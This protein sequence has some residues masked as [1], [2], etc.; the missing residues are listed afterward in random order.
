M[1]LLVVLIVAIGIP[2]AGN[3]EAPEGNS[4]GTL[5]LCLRTDLGGTVQKGVVSIYSE[6]TKSVVIQQRPIEDGARVQLPYGKYTLSLNSDFISDVTRTVSINK[7]ENLLVLSGQFELP[8]ASPETASV[9]IETPGIMSCT[10]SQLIWV[11]LVGVFSTAIYEAPLRKNGEASFV[12]DHGM[13][14]VIVVDG[15]AIRALETFN[16]FGPVTLVHPKVK[17]CP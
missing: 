12:V 17:P 16:T 8:E 1:Y 9:G 11:K 6:V 15:T 3:A 10:K 2:K 13:Y 5:T 14:T 4:S 7:P